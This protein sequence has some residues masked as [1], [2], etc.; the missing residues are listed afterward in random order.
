MKTILNILTLGLYSL[1]SKKKSLDQTVKKKK[2]RDDGTL[3]KE[4][5]RTTTYN[6]DQGSTE[7]PK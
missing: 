1:L 6:E 3:K 7:L 2:Y 4:I 5:E